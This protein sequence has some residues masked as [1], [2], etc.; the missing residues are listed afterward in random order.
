[1]EQIITEKLTPTKIGATK[2]QPYTNKKTGQ[3]DSFNKVGFQTREQGDRWYNLAF[4]GDVPIRE[5]QTYTFDVK[6]REYNGKT[7]YDVASW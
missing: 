7:Y 3:P 4:R 5:G 2:V 1:M 6:S